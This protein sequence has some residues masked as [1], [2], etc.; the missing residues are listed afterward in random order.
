METTRR[1]HGAR[2]AAPFVCTA[3]VLACTSTAALAVERPRVARAAVGVTWT[4]EPVCRPAQP[5]HAT[6]FAMRLVARP[7]GN[8]SAA[9]ASRSVA[10]GPTGGLTPANLAKAYGVNVNAPAAAGQTVAVVDAFND[11]N[12]L[13]DLNTFDANY[14]IA[15]ETAT[16]FRVVNQIGAPS[17]LPANDAGWA[18]E[19]SLDVEAVRAVCRKC[20]IVL[21][22]ATSNSFAN[23][24]AS[25]DTAAT[26]IA[27]T[28]ISN[29]Y[30]GPE[31]G[32][33]PAVAASYDHPSVAILAS[34]GDDGWY[35]W[36]SF[37]EGGSSNNQPNVPASLATVVAVGGTSLY[38]NPDGTRQ[39]EQVWNSNG[40]TDIYGFN[41]GAAMGASG[42]GCST[43]TAPK[44]WQRHV[45]GYDALGCHGTRSVGDIAA[46][47]DPFTGF[48]V[49][50]TFGGA[51]WT[52]IGGTSLS[53]P[54]IAGM[55]ALAG[56]PD[57][58]S[59]PSLSLYGHFATDAST[60]LNDV[61]LGGNGLC[62]TAT[63]GSCGANSGGNPNTLGAGLL[64]CEFGAS[65]TTPLKNGYQCV[66]RPGY[67]GPTGVGTPKG[68]SAF[69]AMAPTA[70]FSA[71]P[72]VTHGVNATFHASGSTDP[73][74]GGT[75]VK[76][77]WKWGDGTTST[78]T[79]VPS[80]THKYATAGSKS[81]K[82]TVTDNYGRS[83]TATKAIT[84]A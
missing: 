43:Q 77:V 13:S 8:S 2:A 70:A 75:I 33:A 27:A 74:P 45:T 52:T 65:G 60:S 10:S 16:T 36:D 76:Y 11:P 46:V 71:P 22:E 7:G 42:G 32:T 25:E 41:L 6:C 66:A 58:V 44:G 18:A 81:V 30:G 73:F 54:L 62:G 28:I 5:H 4:S 56:G 59:Y 84:V 72:T 50:L 51:G 80:A 9:G 64:D 69:T 82:L 53:A 37:N 23:L 12:I 21:V 34:T 63:V 67:D 15:T 14:G 17:P 83:D 68:V 3:L 57:G 47:G 31:A 35:G 48:D 26:T 78:T 1:R 29:S 20:K 40:P 79:T 24:A 19:A 38:F 39:S 49:Y 61:S 55:W